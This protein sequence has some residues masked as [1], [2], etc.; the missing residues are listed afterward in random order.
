[1]REFLQLISYWSVCALLVHT[2]VEARGS[3]PCLL[4]CSASYYFWE[5]GLLVNLELAV[6]SDVAGITDLA[7]V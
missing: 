7:S 3:C 5:Q 2:S 4:L 1:M 6:L